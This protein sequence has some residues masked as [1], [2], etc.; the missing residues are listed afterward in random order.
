MHVGAMRAATSLDA[1][2]DPCS[3]EGANQQEHHQRARDRDACAVLLRE[4]GGCTAR[5][6]FGTRLFRSSISGAGRGD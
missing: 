2:D 6:R 3:R 5:R 4:A 1:T